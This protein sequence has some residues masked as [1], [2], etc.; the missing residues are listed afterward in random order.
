MTSSPTLGNRPWGQE[1][2]NESW[3]SRVPMVQIWMLSDEWFVRCTPLEKLPRNSVK[4]FVI[5]STN[6]TDVRT[7]EWTNKWNGKNY[8]PLG[9]NAG[10]IKIITHFKC[11]EDSSGESGHQWLEFQPVSEFQE[12]IKRM[13]LQHCWIIVDFG[14]CTVWYLPICRLSVK[15]LFKNNTTELLSGTGTVLELTF[16]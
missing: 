10:G 13:V 5:N 6:M 7:N 8:K 1:S 15:E 4:N 16:F 2:W 9:I 14:F 3:P 11:S 12:Q